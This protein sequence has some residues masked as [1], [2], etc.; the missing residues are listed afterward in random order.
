M[1]TLGES[2]LIVKEVKMEIK[3]SSFSEILVKGIIR[4]KL[5][6]STIILFVI[7]V[8][9]RVVT[10]E[11]QELFTGADY[12]FEIIVQLS[13]GSVVSILFYMFL[14]YIPNYRKSLSI[15][16]Q[17]RMLSY[18]L[19]SNLY[20]VKISSTEKRE[21]LNAITK[22]NVD[23]FIKHSCTDLNEENNMKTYLNSSYLK[24]VY[25]FI[26]EE[27]LDVITDIDETL[28]KKLRYLKV[29]TIRLVGNNTDEIE[30]LLLE[31]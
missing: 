6:I 9:L 22:M 20:C 5:F 27:G 30:F 31:A 10:N 29:N 13:L 28:Y 3:E 26:L 4:T 17:Y 18:Q 11:V 21:E 7:L 8:F 15:V 14:V 1:G 19:V 24:T 25:E 16:Q 23:E 2:I 12:V